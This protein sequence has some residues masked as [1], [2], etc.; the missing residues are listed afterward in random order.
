MNPS[1]AVF[2]EAETLS[3][4]LPPSAQNVAS[5][6]LK[7]G[8]ALVPAPFLPHQTRE[9]GRFNHFLGSRANLQFTP[10]MTVHLESLPFWFAVLIP[11]AA[12]STSGFN[13]VLGS[14]L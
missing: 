4:W 1:H 8:L 11:I 13:T 14:A 12:A 5:P 7:P 3:N 10:Y 6:S 9:P 2:R